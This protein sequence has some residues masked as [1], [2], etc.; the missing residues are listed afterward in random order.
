[1]NIEYMT[2][3]DFEQIKDNLI[4]EFDDFWSQS[5]LKNDIEKDNSKYVVAKENDEIVGFGGIWILPD[6]VQISNIV[7]KKNK[8]KKGI[9]SLLLDRLIEIAKDT[10]KDSISLEVNEKNTDAINLYEKNEFEILGQR[11]NYY[12]GKDNAIIMTKYFK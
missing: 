5:M 10:K 7:V 8:R 1:M 9:G 4:E 3:D 6:D 2:I 11:K 12:N